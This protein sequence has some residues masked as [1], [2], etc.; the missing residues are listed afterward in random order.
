MFTK[1]LALLAGG[2]LASSLIT[3]AVAQSDKMYRPEPAP[4]AIIYRDMGYQG[5]A[6]NVS[7]PQPD[8]GLAWRVNAVRVVSGEW[9][10]C[11]G[12]NYRGRCRT[13]NRDTAMLGNPFRGVPVQSM[14]PVGYTA[15]GGEPGDNMS[16]RGMAAEFYP[17]P[18][19]RG[20]RVPACETGSATAACAARTAQQFC[21]S[22][23]WRRST[24]QSMESVRGTA[25]LADVLCS[26]TG[27]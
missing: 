26:N 22:M 24:R 4:E 14:R 12:T 10:L 18:A 5:P 19:L 9:Q 27:T 11:E 17:K 1:S 3:V 15:P 13:V 23:G 21:S 8:L 25:Y 7:Q 16:L 6:V 20:Y 2:V